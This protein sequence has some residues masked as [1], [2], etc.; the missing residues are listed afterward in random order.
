LGLGRCWAAVYVCDL[1][2]ST[3]KGHA[4]MV[5]AILEAAVLSQGLTRAKKRCINHSNS[6][7]QSA[8]M[9]ACISG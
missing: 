1:W 4:R 3:G 2:F 7:G 6:K 5:Q 9:L 8:L